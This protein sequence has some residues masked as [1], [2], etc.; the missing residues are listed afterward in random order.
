MATHSHDHPEPVGDQ[1][2]VA[3][4]STYGAE[5]CPWASRLPDRRDV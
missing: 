4:G 1:V 5:E 3:H 2:N